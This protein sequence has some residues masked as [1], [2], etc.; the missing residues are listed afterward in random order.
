MAK[1]LTT[2][3][4]W[5]LAVEFALGAVT[6]YWPG[7]TVFSAAYSTKFVDWGYPSWMRFVVGALEGAAAVL[8]VVPSRRTRFLAATTLVFVLT[9]AVTTHIVN[10]DPAAE[11]WA[12]PTHLVIMGIIALANW[13]ADWRDVLRAPTRSARGVEGPPL[14]HG[15]RAR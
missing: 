5:L 4:Y 2:G 8:L 7:D 12:A 14:T 1:R 9:G 10:H 6:K 13:P 11:S 15:R 3:L